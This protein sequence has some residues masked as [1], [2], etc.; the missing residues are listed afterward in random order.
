MLGVPPAAAAGLCSSTAT[1]AWETNFADATVA[2]VAIDV[3]GC[4]DGEAVGIQLLLDD[5]SELPKDGPL[6]GQVSGERAVFDVSGLDIR[7]EPV[8][9]IRVFLELSGGEQLTYQVTVDR[10]FFSSAGSEQV[11]LRQLTVL[12]VPFGSSYLVPG[13]PNRYTEVRCE[14]VGYAPEDASDEGSGTF[15]ATASGRHI[16]CFQQVPGA[17]G[18][19]PPGPGGPGSEQ[20]IVIP[21]DDASR[22]GE[23]PSD[24]LD[25][26]HDRGSDD[27]LD[28]EDSDGSDV[29]GE[30]IDRRGDR[31]LGRLAMTG[32]DLLVAV[33]VGLMTVGIGLGLLRRRRA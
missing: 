29:L 11:G 8:T 22:G 3:P 5:E 14:T 31:V 26:S 10:R 18:G 25:E 21:P 28:A 20:P 33:A 30:V 1:V 13:A 27:L 6:M 16:A 19:Q 32:S 9:G 23:D 12:N 24:V 15:S 17:P 2:A 4:S 7:I